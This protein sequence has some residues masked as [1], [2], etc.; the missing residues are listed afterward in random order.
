M[1]HRQASVIRLM[2]SAVLVPGLQSTDSIIT[3]HGL[4][5]SATCGIFPDQ[6]S[7]PALAGGFFTT[8]PPGRS[9]DVFVTQD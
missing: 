2:G 6:G 3:V 5:C 7:S 1:E 8:E 9:P 4:S